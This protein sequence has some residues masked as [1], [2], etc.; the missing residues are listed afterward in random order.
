MAAGLLAGCSSSGGSSAAPCADGGAK[1]AD[2]SRSTTSSSASSSKKTDAGGTSSSTAATT[3]RASTTNATST[4]S[5][6]AGRADS[7][8]SSTSA[9]RCEGGACTPGQQ[10]CSDSSHVETCG[11]DCQWGAPWPCATGACAGSSCTGGTTTG[12]SC[13]AADGGAAACL[14]ADGGVESCCTSV[15]VPGGTYAR[16]YVSADGGAAVPS[17]EADPAT[18]SGLRLDR[19]LVTV[20]RFRQFVAAWDTGLGWLPTAGAGKHAHLNGGEGLVSGAGGSH[21]P[22]WASG[23]DAQIQPTDTNLSCMPVW[24]TWTTSPSG[25]ETLP[26]DCV[27]WYEAYAFCIWDGGFLP[28][29]AEWEYAA[30]GG[31]DQREYPWGSADP[32]TASKYAIYDCDYGASTAYCS[33]TANVAP[34]GTATLGAARWGQ[35]DM[36]GEVDEWAL[37]WYASSYADPCVDCASLTPTA[38]RVLRGGYFVSVAPLLESSLRGGTDP[39]KRDNSTGFRC[40]RTP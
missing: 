25:Q 27:N 31:S 19:Y 39:T 6:D 16:T 29:E 35:L 22:G 33:G 18:V 8:T 34:V 30:A 4:S 10:Q 12:T 14:A 3:S 17:S 2:A 11:D 28:S 13:I 15:E 7:A 5:S 36:A 32:G 9:R 40:A 26:I 38:Y 1:G 24:D 23:D 20:G 21:E 37:D